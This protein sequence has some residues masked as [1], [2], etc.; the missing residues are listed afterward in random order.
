MEL[1]FVDYKSALDECDSPEKLADLMARAKQ[2]LTPSL[3]EKLKQLANR[4]GG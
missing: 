4:A 2:F 1:R 3:Y